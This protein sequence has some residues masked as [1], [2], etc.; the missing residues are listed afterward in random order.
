[1]ATRIELD[2][3]TLSVV[4]EGEG[5]AVLLLHGFPDRA[6]MWRRQVDTLVAAGYRVVAPDLRGFGDSDR[7]QEPGAYRMRVLV[8]D[9]TGLLDALDVDAASVVGHDWGA[10]LAWAFA[11]RRPER[12]RRLVALSVGHAGTGP[13]AGVAQRRLSWYMLWFLLPG[14]AEQ[15]LPADDWAF[16]RTWAWDGEDH[17]GLR[18]QVADLSRP[19]ALT[20]A[21]GWYRANV[22]PVRFAALEAGSVPHVSCPTM[23]VWSDQDPFL[24][25]EQMAG[26]G[27]FVDAEWRYERLSGVDHWIAERAPEALDALLLDFLAPTLTGQQPGGAEPRVDP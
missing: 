22:D 5:P 25:E 14:V 11:M 4:D 18:R 13:A 27:A 23:G 3:V 26:S 16:F 9:L 7:P 8:G 1:V 24:G 20:A 17:P 2:D 21:L 10:G 15:A 6:E 12:T 19:G